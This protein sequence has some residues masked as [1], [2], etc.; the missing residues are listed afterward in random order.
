[1]AIKNWAY[2]RNEMRSLAQKI[3]TAIGGGYVNVKNDK[4]HIAGQMFTTNDV[5]TGAEGKRP[6][7]V[8]SDIKDVVFGKINANAIIDHVGCGWE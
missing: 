2:S 1:M 7:D 8:R 4:F 6:V 5:L 3:A